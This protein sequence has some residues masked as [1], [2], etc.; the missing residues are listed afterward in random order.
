LPAATSSSRACC[1]RSPALPSELSV[2]AIATLLA[3][4]ARWLVTVRW[5]LASARSAR[6]AAAGSSLARA[7]RLP[8]VICSCSFESSL[9]RCCS[10]STPESKALAVA[11]RM[12]GPQ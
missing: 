9:W 10:V 2:C 11:I 6:A 7:T 12:N 5:T 3:S 1:I 4:T 8:E